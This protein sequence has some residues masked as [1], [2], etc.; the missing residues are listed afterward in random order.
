MGLAM[1]NFIFFNATTYHELLFICVIIGW[2]LTI[3]RKTFSIL[4][5]YSII[6]IYLEQHFSSP[7]TSY[8]VHV[9]IFIWANTDRRWDMII[10]MNLDYGVTFCKSHP[11]TIFFMVVGTTAYTPL[12][13]ILFLTK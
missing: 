4:I 12:F 10:F 7:L 1:R 9:Y 2:E 3:K 11:S 8:F 6:F 13:N 5:L